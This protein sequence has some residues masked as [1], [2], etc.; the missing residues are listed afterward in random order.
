[1]SAAANGSI[2]SRA[3]ENV[4]PHL[5]RTGARREK[6]RRFLPGFE[7]VFARGGG[8]RSG[9]GRD[10]GALA[11]TSRVTSGTPAAGPAALAR[12]PCDKGWGRETAARSPMECTAFGVRARDVH[13]AGAVGRA[14]DRAHR[15]IAQRFE[16][17]RVPDVHT[18][19]CPPHMRTATLTIE[20]HSATSRCRQEISTPP[21]ACVAAATLALSFRMYRGASRLGGRISTCPSLRA[22]LVRAV[23]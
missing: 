9:V 13:N 23:G 3:A 2:F 1:M 16:S 14:G 8:W 21:D 11:S 12:G 17:R 10:G 18:S 6:P 22:C 4:F 5:A 20:I 7:R 15:S 19:I